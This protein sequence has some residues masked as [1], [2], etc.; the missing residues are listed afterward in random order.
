MH[1]IL[2]F[3]FITTISFQPYLSAQ[4]ENNNW[5]FGTGTDGILFDLN[6][7]PQK[8]SNKMSG[9]GFEGMIVVNNPMTG[10]LL[11][12][13]NGQ[14][15]V[16][17]NHVV[18]PNGN[19]LNGHYSGAQCVQCCPIPGS[20]AKKFYLFTNSAWD[21][22]SGKIYY[23]I[24]D[25]TNDPL[26]VVTSK[27]ILIWDGPSDEG[28]CLVNKPNTNDY[29]LITHTSG[30]PKYNV[31]PL[32]SSGIGSP[33]PYTFSSTGETYQMNYSSI[34]KKIV[35]TGYGNIHVTLLDFNAT[36]GV[37]SNEVQLGTS[38]GNCSAARFSPDGTKLYANRALYPPSLVQYLFQYDFATSTWTNMNTCCY[39]H[40]LKIGPDGRMYFIHSYN[41]SQPISIIDY[42]NLSAV[43]NACNY[44]D[45]TFS[46]PFNGEVRRFP[47]IVTLPVP[48]I[49]NTDIVSNPLKTVSIDVLAN[50]YSQS[51]EVI[52]LDAIVFPPKYGTATI[53]NAKINYAFAEKTC[54]L[55]DTLI[56][57]IR[58][59]S[60]NS[61]TASVIITNPNPTI[62]TTINSTICEGD[63]YN[64]YTLTGTYVDI[65]KAKKG[66][67]SF[68]TLNLVVTPA[69]RTTISAT[70]CEGKQYL[71]YSKAGT[72]T[73]TFI[74]A[75]GC[76][77]IRTLQLSV[78]AAVRFTLNATICEGKQYS[79]YTKAGTYIDT[80]IAA[81][82][83]DS[84]RT[85]QLSVKAAA[86]FTLNA[87]ICEGK[88]YLGY[89]NAGT[90]IDTLIAINGCDSIR[91]L[92]LT[93]MPASRSAVSA[94]ICE[95]HQYL[96]YTKTG[97][98]ID[99]FISATGCDSIRTLQLT[100]MTNPVPDLGKDTSI[101][102]GDKLL[103]YPGEF[104]SY[105]W[106][107]GSTQN[108]LEVAKEGTYFVSVTNKCGTK[109]DEIV[110]S[111]GNCTIYFPNAFSPNGNGSNDY[112]KILNAK[113]IKDYHLLIYNRWGQKVFE[114]FDFNKGWDGKLNGVDSPTGIFVWLCQFSQSGTIKNLKGTVLLI[115]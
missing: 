110:V 3:F 72:Y 37:L 24:V 109:Q 106:Q 49:A 100:V 102:A 96:G 63:N 59:N 66:C 6:N 8:V 36:T 111:S 65:F 87:T 15:V 78:K 4:I 76:D 53:Q 69:S 10:A 81:S 32:T 80:L 108:K 27:N 14:N 26:G 21:N 91:I 83:C 101:C 94:T 25:F 70:I 39:A 16:N 13:S 47:E 115:R 42:P 50:D 77:S 84:I 62:K 55:T 5:Y 54:E 31:I 71:G 97:T 20:C 99:T 44:H 43:G 93:V 18:M 64:G 82:G 17:S 113:N 92:Q 95:G 86:R 19:N 28:M 79:G 103:L 90:Y 61:N 11:F 33:I 40:D 75:S 23:S 74:A 114:T 85:L 60:C 68:R 112:F 48:P 7:K 88:Q 56:Y 1:K 73:D 46:I 38:F 104:E 89:A 67:D 51:G 34:A 52:S 9:V 107:N 30:T 98:Y 22:T 2:L 41:D 57:R 12:Y 58:D 45:T 35:A 105:L 29:W